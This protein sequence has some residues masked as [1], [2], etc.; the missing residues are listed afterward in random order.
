M[1]AD[2]LSGKESGCLPTPS[3]T[4]V[5]GSGSGRNGRDGEEGANQRRRL[6]IVGA[7]SH[8]AIQQLVVGLLP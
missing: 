6:W 2:R 5:C 1:C 4:R 7:A 3:P 8:T